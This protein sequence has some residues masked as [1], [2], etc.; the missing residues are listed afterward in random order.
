[1]SVVYFDSVSSS[2]STVTIFD[3]MTVVLMPFKL[4]VK[5]HFL[6]RRQNIENNQISQR[7]IFGSIV[8]FAYSAIV[9]VLFFCAGDCYSFFVY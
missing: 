7:T 5:Y 3:F 8:S 4:H 1:M 2:I 9:N 6:K